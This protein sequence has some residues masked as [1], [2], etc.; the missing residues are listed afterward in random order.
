VDRRVKERLI[1]ACILVVLAVAV[2]PEL[3]S[4]PKP[5]APGSVVDAAGAVRLPAGAPD[6]VRNVTVDLAT[7]KPAMA[8]PVVTPAAQSAAAGAVPAG[9]A[10]AD[11]VPTNGAP[12]AASPPLAAAQAS[13]IPASAA[14][15][16]VA[17]TPTPN[18]ASA[19][20]SLETP[21]AL[22]TS[23]Q[24]LA[25]QLGSFANRSNADKLVHQLKAKGFAIYMSA[26]GSG[27][28]TRY[29]VRVGPFA[30]R[31]AAERMIAKLK[32]VGQAASIVSAR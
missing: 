7:A 12:S 3:L 18:D 21:A 31:D 16:S 15:G 2:V 6:P 20:H 19:A 8:D 28:A 29:R 4:G 10:Q 26:E 5:S 30:D 17:A 32:G 13:A 11:T 24:S 25:V 1:G 27:A 14:P 23:E 9:A 22:P